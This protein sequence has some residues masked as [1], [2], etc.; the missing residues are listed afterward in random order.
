MEY[1][2]GQILLYEDY[3]IHQVQLNQVNSEQKTDIFLT[4]MYFGK[5]LTVG[6]VIGFGEK[7]IHVSELAE[8]NS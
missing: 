5:L 6:I 2:P 3:D 8:N 7:S 1:Q 4:L